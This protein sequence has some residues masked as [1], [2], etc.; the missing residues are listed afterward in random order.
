MHSFESNDAAEAHEPRREAWPSALPDSGRM[1]VESTLTA[2]PETGQRTADPVIARFRAALKGVQTSELDR[3]YRRL[4]ELDDHSRLVIWQ[5]ADSIVAKMLQPPL[6]CLR[7]ESHYGSPHV[8][9]EALQQ[10]FRLCD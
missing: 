8:L 10:L 7:D 6:E 2:D 1:I 3:L 5:F 9:L 4:P